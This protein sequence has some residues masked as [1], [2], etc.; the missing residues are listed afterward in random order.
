MQT[1]TTETV[2][3]TE[4]ATRA[5]LAAF[6]DARTSGGRPTFCATVREQQ[7]PEI[8]GP[9]CVWMMAQPRRAADDIAADLEAWCLVE[10]PGLAALLQPASAA[11][12]EP[13]EPAPALC[14]PEP[15]GK[16]RI[17]AAFDQAVQ[18]RTGRAG[19]GALVAADRAVTMEMCADA[20]EWINA[21]PAQRA[22]E[23]R[24]ALV[25]WL[26]APV[27]EEPAELPT[28]EAQPAPVEAPAE[29]FEAP[30]D[31][32]AAGRALAG[33]V[34]TTTDDAP[35][36]PLEA[37]PAPV[38]ELP[39][40]ELPPVEL[41]AVEPGEDEAGEDEAE[42][43]ADDAE[44]EDEPASDRGPALAV[45][46][47][48]A[49]R[50][51]AQ[52]EEILAG[53]P[54]TVRNPFE[55]DAFCQMLGSK[56]GTTRDI[57]KRVRLVALEGVD[58]GATVED[59][60]SRKGKTR[61]RSTMRVLTDCASLKA[62][63]KLDDKTRAAI[64]KLMRKPH[65][66]GGALYPIPPHRVQKVQA[67]VDQWL[68]DRAALVERLGDEYDREVERDRDVIRE[69]LGADLWSADDYPDRLSAIAR[70]SASAAWVDVIGSQ[71][72]DTE[73][74]ERNQ[75]AMALQQRAAWAEIRA[76][77]RITAATLVDGLAAMLKPD[78]LT[79]KKPR[80]E[81]SRIAAM[82]EWLE[83]FRQMDVTDDVELA[84]IADSARALMDGVA[85]PA[86]LKKSDSARLALASKLE[87]VQAGLRTLGVAETPVRKVRKGKAPKPSED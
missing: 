41:P 79:G 31:L 81:D 78:P 20:I 68:A 9:V 26:E 50:I 51:S 65:P 60:K 66:F 53:A 18:D 45:E 85:D 2:W 36:A 3:T 24:A 14:A 42:P 72:L 10:I 75:A 69:S 48:E 58:Q 74:K 4:A 77:S 63:G 39:P 11:P 62:I 67:I 83:D 16:D 15:A 73:M 27:V 47:S 12:V 54:S 29:V 23:L 86:T 17:L 19:F 46:M 87:A 59:S 6:Q 22:P 38:V 28:V 30:A 33:L 80:F 56:L 7:P 84:R 49:D 43:A 70:Y 32:A 13:A 37:E 5:I 57:R 8:A 76:A 40:V 34:G 21:Q 25:A 71:K 61:A 82:R 1:T 55:N 35:P 52:A 44:D 64:R